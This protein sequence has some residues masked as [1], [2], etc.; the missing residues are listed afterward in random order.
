MEHILSAFNIGPLGYTVVSNLGARNHHARF[1]QCDST[2]GDGLLGL[3]VD[4]HGIG[5]DGSV[6]LLHLHV[7]AEEERGFGHFAVV[8]GNLQVG[9]GRWDAHVHISQGVCESPSALSASQ[10]R[11]LRRNY[12]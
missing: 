4:L 8:S 1:A 5:L 6:P 2:F 9:L 10:I 12:F 3:A 7:A 11:F